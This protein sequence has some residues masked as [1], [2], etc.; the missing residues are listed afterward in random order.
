MEKHVLWHQ[1]LTKIIPPTFPV[2]LSFERKNRRMNSE[3]P[4]S[5]LQLAISLSR[6]GYSTEEI[7]SQLRING[8]TETL[9]QKAID[10]VKQLR[11]T[12]RR[13][14]GFIW[15]GIG[16]FLLVSG[17][18]ITFIQYN[19]GQNI[20]IAMYGLTSIG[21]VAIIKGLIDLFGW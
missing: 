4:E 3:Q 19:S 20:R 14:T 16:T 1:Y 11:L 13:N 9:L 12:S 18:M 2:F 21:V 8:A 17:C 5:L 7:A 6:K 10:E 15:C